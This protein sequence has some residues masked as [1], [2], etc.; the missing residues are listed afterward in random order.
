MT[1]DDVNEDWFAH[2]SSINM[3]NLKTLKEGQKISFD[4]TQSPKEKQG[5]NIQSA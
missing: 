2:I 4:I 1:P 5:T 3:G